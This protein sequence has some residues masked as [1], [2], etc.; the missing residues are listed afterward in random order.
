M[1]TQTFSF[2]IEPMLSLCHAKPAARLAFLDMKKKK[3]YFLSQ[4]MKSAYTYL[5]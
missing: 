1:H 2:S 5:A 4:E 3:R